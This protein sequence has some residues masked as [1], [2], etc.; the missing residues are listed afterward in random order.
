MGDG[1]D[2]VEWSFAVNR[3]D[4]GCEDE[5]CS[6]G[7]QCSV[8]QYLSTGCNNSVQKTLIFIVLGAKPERLNPLWQYMTPKITSFVLK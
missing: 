1:Y 4:I 8:T 6:L 3:V 5:R 7:V 2:C